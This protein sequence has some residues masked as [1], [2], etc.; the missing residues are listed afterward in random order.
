[1]STGTSVVPTIS[2]PCHGMAKRTRPSAVLG[3]I[4]AVF[5]GRNERGKNEMRSLADGKQRTARLSVE[6]EGIFGVN[7]AGIDHRL[8]LQVEDSA[9]FAVARLDT[10][11]LASALDE[12]D[13]FNVVDG[14]AAEILKRAQQRD[15]V[16]GVVKLAVVIEN[17]AAQV[18][19]L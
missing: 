7:A 11:D 12:A 15:G 10:D 18:I 13:G 1:M 16:A 14:G 4:S 17:A 9:V 5:P 6:R 8:G 2:A 3:I 19:A